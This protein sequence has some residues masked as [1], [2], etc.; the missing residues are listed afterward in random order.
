MDRQLIAYLLIAALVAIFAFIVVRVRY[1]S[2][3]NVLKRQR[4]AD[5]ARRTARRNAREVTAGPASL[6]RG[7]DRLDG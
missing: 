3:P 6:D 1:Q 5:E 2:R 7:T 4:N